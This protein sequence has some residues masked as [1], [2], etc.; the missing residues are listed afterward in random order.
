M[1]SQR[2]GYNWATFLTLC[3]ERVGSFIFLEGGWHHLSPAGTASDHLKGFTLKPWLPLYFSA[4]QCLQVVVDM[5]WSKWDA[6]SSGIF[7]VSQFSA[8]S[9]FLFL[10]RLWKLKM[11]VIH[12]QVISH[13]KSQESCPTLCNFLDYRP[14]GSSDGIFQAILEWV[15]GLGR[16]L[17]GGHS[18][19]LQY[20]CWENPMDR[21]VCWA[22]VHGVAKRYNW[23]D[24]HGMARLKYLLV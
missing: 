3:I 9:P 17:G 16:S 18:S 13:V 4:F 7:N 19:P 10:W 23:S 22:S 5:G 1:G 24:E 14:P 12:V 15:P 21:G 6:S 2:V 8:V 20:S 11:L